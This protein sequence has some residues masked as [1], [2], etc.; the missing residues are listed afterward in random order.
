MER[1]RNRKPTDICIGLLLAIA[2]CM[3]A[4]RQETEVFVP[5]TEQLDTGQ[6]QG[7]LL[8]F[9]LLNEGN[10]GSI[11]SILGVK[12]NTLQRGLNIVNGRKV[13]VK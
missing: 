11:Y 13:F 12:R 1:K 7:K 4:C 2:A 3:G 10:M 9:Y 6:A 8:G 5:E